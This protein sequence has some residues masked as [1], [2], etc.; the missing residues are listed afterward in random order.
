MNHEE[1][2]MNELCEELNITRPTI[3]NYMKQGMPH[4]R[5]WDGLR[6]KNTY[7]VQDVKEW[8]EKQRGKRGK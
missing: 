1:V 5:A 7:S 6:Y 2:T 3:Y 4:K 8:I